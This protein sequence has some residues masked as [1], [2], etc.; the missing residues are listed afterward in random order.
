MVRQAL[1]ELGW[2]LE[3]IEEQ[4]ADA[5][6]GNGGLGRLAACFMDSLASLG[7]AGHGCGIR[8][9]YG[10]FEQ[11]IVDGNQVELP[12]YWLQKGNVWEERR[13]D[14]KIEVHFW[15]RVETREQEG[16]LVFET[17]DAETVWAVPYD[18]PLV[19]YGHAQVNTLR[20]WSAESALD[21]VRGP[22]RGEGGYY[23]FRLQSIGGIDLSISISG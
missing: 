4:E 23:R 1:G 21:P 7:Y 3:E 20:I 18:I 15:G 11:R 16:R 22:I 17:Q 13:P 9:K 2:D 14:K 8:Y 10:L 12:D 6:L 19:G 5:G